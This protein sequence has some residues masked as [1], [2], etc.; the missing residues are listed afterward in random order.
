MLVF[1]DFD[2]VLHPFPCHYA[3]HFC[4]RNLLEDFFRQ[5]AQADARFVISST[6]RNHYPL[7]ELRRWFSPDFHDRIIGCTPTLDGIAWE[8]S[9]ERE[10]QAWRQQHGSL[11]EAWIALDDMPPFFEPECDNV[12]F[13]DASTGFAE[14]DCAALTEHI[15]RIR[16]RY[17]HTS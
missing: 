13:C 7:D 14:K 1:L 11:H 10:I 17:S 15:A 3:L 12:Y 5:P 4:Q 16:P 2:G 6:W 9:R 8:G